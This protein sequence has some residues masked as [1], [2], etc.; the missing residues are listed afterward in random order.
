MDRRSLL[1]GAAAVGAATPAVATEPAARVVSG[2]ADTDCGVHPSLAK[3]VRTA[4]AAV[5]GEA[6]I[7]PKDEAM[8]VLYCLN[9]SLRLPRDGDS[10][11][12]RESIERGNRRVGE[13]VG[14]G[15][16]RA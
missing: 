8:M 16:R 15:G 12:M 4:C 3:M 7:L 10:E 1:L 13:L 14:R 2:D 11:S 5:A 6:V 9:K